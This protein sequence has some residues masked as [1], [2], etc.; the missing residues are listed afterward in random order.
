[1]HNPLPIAEVLSIYELALSVADDF[2]LARIIVG[3]RWRQFEVFSLVCE[4]RS[5]VVAVSCETKGI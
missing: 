3:S 4:D 5:E 2:C 1:M